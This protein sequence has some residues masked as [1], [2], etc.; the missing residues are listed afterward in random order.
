VI[1]G[2]IKAMG[3]DVAYMK[4]FGDRLIYRKKRLWDHDS[5]L[6]TEVFGLAEDP[7][8]LSVGFDHTKIMFAYDEKTIAKRL[9]DMVGRIGKGK[10]ILFIEGGRNIEYG[11]SVNLDAMTVVRLVGGEMILV[12]SGD[13]GTMLDDIFFIRNMID[14]HT[15]PLK[16][17]I[18]NK[19]RDI[20][21]FESTFG[22]V[23]KKTGVPVLGMIPFREE[24]AYLS[25][26][27]VADWLMA[28]VIAGEEGLSRRIKTILVGAM[29]TD[30]LLRTSLLQQEDKL[31]ITAGDRS[32]MIVTALDSNASAVVLTNNIIP[33]PNII[34]RA[35][36]LGIP[37]LLVDVDT[38]KAAKRIDD[39]EPL[40]TGKETEKIDLLESMIKE[41][42]LDI[43]AI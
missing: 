21:G 36:D 23:L 40:L 16:G 2:A 17:I 6:I 13:E 3:K 14:T 39:M 18:L 8:D 12:V 43:G 27:Y 7:V 34:S 37:L 24:L 9:N 28:K 4:P 19:V 11:M 32:D 25:V 26:R 5:A 15:L 41:S 29:S 10:D 33:P 22:A 31:I 38:F 35:S 20:E 1:V 30:A 42:G